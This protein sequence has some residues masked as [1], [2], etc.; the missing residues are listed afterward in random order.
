ML[1]PDTIIFNSKSIQLLINIRTGYFFTETRAP[2]YICIM[3][4]ERTYHFLQS[5]EFTLPYVEYGNGEELLLAFHGFGRSSA[6]F[7]ALE[8]HLGR[9]Y[10]IVAFDF[11]YHGPHGLSPLQ[12]IPVFTP[13]HLSNMIE[14]LLWEKKKVRCSLM[15]YSQGG[16]IILGLVHHLPHRI[17]EMFVLAPDG[18]KENSIRN[19]IGRTAPGRLLGKYLVKHPSLLFGTIRLLKKSGFIS[20]KIEQFYLLNTRMASDRFRIYHTWLTL[21]NYHPHPELIRHYFATRPIR[22][23]FFMGKYDSIIPGHLAT[24][25]L[26][27]MT[28]NISLSVLE[29]GH[30]LLQLHAEISEKILVGHS[31]QNHLKEG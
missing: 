23:E 24:R 17:H 28:G 1:V 15:G 12:E 13:T 8:Q 11:F 18:L 14:K 26:E 30:D 31:G 10:T 7:S 9:H 4:T 27:K 2:E 20:Q 19:F 5:D 16:R 21:R 29:C 6:D 22:V 3:D 25:F